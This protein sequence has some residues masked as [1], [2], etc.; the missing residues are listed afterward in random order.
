MFKIPKAKS[1]IPEH[2]NGKK[3]IWKPFFLFMR[4]CSKLASW[5][6]TPQLFLCLQSFLKK[7]AIIA[8][9]HGQKTLH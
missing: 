1:G 3:N 2:K 9:I 7:A 5:N 6:R 4:L 8:A